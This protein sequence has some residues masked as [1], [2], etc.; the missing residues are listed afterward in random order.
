MA[1]RIH[2]MSLLMPPP[3]HILSPALIRIVGRIVSPVVGHKQICKPNAAAVGE[4]KSSDLL[5]RSAKNYWQ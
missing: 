4:V 3:G 5:S 1:G 2:K